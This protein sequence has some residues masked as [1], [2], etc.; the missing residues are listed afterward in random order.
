MTMSFLIILLLSFYEC[1]RD[2][3][4][5]FIHFNKTVKE[6][7]DV[8]F[9]DMNMKH[10]LLGLDWST[11]YGHYWI[12]C[13]IIKEFDRMRT[14]NTQGYFATH[15]RLLTDNDQQQ[16]LNNLILGDVKTNNRA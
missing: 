14:T 13:K 5:K 11:M 4:N 6:K 8:Y 10:E 1:F 7:L 16:Q 3:S 15:E 2:S 9:A 12:E